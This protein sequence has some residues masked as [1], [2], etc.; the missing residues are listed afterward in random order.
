MSISSFFSSFLNVVHADAAPEEQEKVESTV[1]QE[2]A[3]ADEPEAETEVET[4]E[5]EEEEEEPEDLHPQIRDECK[6]STKCASFTR[7]FEHCQE[8]VTSGQG[9]KGEDC[10]EELCTYERRFPG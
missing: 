6:E 7:H 4:K 1:Q 2:P 9:F 8:K 3:T 10:V 5:E